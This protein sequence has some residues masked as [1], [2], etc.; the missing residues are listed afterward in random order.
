MIKITLLK[1]I[2]IGL[3]FIKTYVTVGTENTVKQIE[4]LL[5]NENI[6][7]SQSWSLI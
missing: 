7:N 3:L 1:N 6:S 2:W 4:T 5:P